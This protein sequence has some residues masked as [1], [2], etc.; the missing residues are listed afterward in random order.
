MR[1]EL[2]ATGLFSALFHLALLQI[3]SPWKGSSDPLEP[4]KELEISIRWQSSILAPQ[5]TS[6]GLF[7]AW[8][9]VEQKEP[10]GD[11]TGIQREK[12]EQ[13]EIKSKW[14]PKEKNSVPRRKPP[15]SK[16]NTKKKQSFEPNES[17]TPPETGNQESVNFGQRGDED[18]DKGPETNPPGYSQL[19]QAQTLP[20]V[21][22]RRALPRYDTNPKPPY[23]DAARRRGQEGLVVLSVLVLKDGSVGRV[24][25]L[26]SSGYDLLDSSALETVAKWRFIPA[27]VGDEPIE[28]EVQVPIR[29]KLE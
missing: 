27:K 24:K 19:N 20:S 23:P 4:Q 5:E 22:L 26:K 14:A 21:E 3:P 12:G 28:M 25:V 17:P 10:L 9:M 13:K 1:K 29:F 11:D 16:P 6:S 8:H 2:I 15:S 7:D 18:Q